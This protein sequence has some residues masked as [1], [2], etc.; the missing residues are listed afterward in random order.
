MYKP[1]GYRG[2]LVIATRFGLLLAEPDTW[3]LPVEDLMLDPDWVD[4]IGLA[5]GPFFMT[6][7]EREIPF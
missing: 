5:D 6:D 1:L 4:L 3:A 2:E 7:K